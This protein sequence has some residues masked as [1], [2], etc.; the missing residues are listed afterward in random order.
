MIR[1]F[2]PLLATALLFISLSAQKIEKLNAEEI[3]A[4]HLDSIGTKQKRAEIKNQMVVGS[5]E[6]IILRGGSSK[7][8]GNAVF[9]SEA[10]RLFFGANYNSANYPSERASFDGE[11]SNFGYVAP[12]LRSAFGNYMIRN[13][14]LFSEGLFGGCLSVAWSL[15]D[16]L[17]RSPKLNTA[18]H[19]KIDGKETYVLEYSPKKGSDSA[20]RLYFDATTFEHVRSEYIQIFSAAQGLTPDQSSQQREGRQ[21]LTEDFS[22]FSIENGLM[23]PHKYSIHLV[24]DG[25]TT[26]EYEWTFQFSKFL[27]NQKL[28]PKSFDIDAK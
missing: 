12:G 25:R 10:T 20:I 1:L 26:T 21:V 16:V 6:F 8:I 14:Q 4:K 22:V 11:K 18:G 24:L 13:K 28:D 23:L 5:S 3:V 19:K 15:H 2:L 9:A 7:T 17:G 27:I